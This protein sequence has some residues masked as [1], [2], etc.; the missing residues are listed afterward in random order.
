MADALLDFV[1]LLPLPLGERNTFPSAH[2]QWDSC[3]AIGSSRRS[4][5]RCLPLS[6]TLSHYAVSHSPDTR[7]AAWPTMGKIA[8]PVIR[9]LQLLCSLCL[10]A[11][12]HLPTGYSSPCPALGMWDR[13]FRIKPGE[14]ID[15]SFWKGEMYTIGEVIAGIHQWTLELFSKRVFECS[16]KVYVAYHIHDFMDT[17]WCY[18]CKYVCLCFFLM[19]VYM[20]VW[21]CIPTY[22]YMYIFPFKMCLSKKCFVSEKYVIHWYNRW[23]MDLAHILKVAHEWPMFG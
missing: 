12:S 23:D 3:T 15:H 21:I 11:C 2:S 5:S 18:V 16:L 13:I 22:K 19:F 14:S 10:V 9:K 17:Q 20:W 1:P 4:T 8:P 7:E 6:F